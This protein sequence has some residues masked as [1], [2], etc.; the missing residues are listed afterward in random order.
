MR[1]VRHQVRASRRPDVDTSGVSARSIAERNHVMVELSTLTAHELGK[2]FDLSV[3]PKQTTEDDI[4][5]GCRAGRALQL[6]R[7]LLLGRLLDAGGA[8]GALRLGRAAGGSGRIPVRF[9]DVAREGAGGRG[10]GGS[11]QS[12]ARQRDEH[13]RAQERASRR[14][15]GGD[16]GVQAGGGR[17]R[18]QGHSGDVL[19]HRR[20]I[21]RATEV[22]V[23]ERIDYAKTSSG[24]FEGPIDGAR[25]ADGRGDERLTRPR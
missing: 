15:P 4:R 12:R 20:E 5:Q 8:R 19:P 11:R 7:V 18:H 23:D 10:G 22:L 1:G 6:R 25:S 3:L 14:R 21:R 16:S 13:R 2:C 9:G 24:Q 17:R